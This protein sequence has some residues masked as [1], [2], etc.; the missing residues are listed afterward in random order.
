MDRL[1]R[2][3]KEQ[4]FDA[5]QSLKGGWYFRKDG[6]TMTFPRTPETPREWSNLIN[7]LRRGGMDLSA[8]DS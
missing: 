5:W 1:L 8:M 3:A 2:V 4:E 6:Q 7:T